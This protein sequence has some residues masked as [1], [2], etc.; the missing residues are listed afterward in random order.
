VSSSSRR[1]FFILIG[2]AEMMM[3]MMIY[4]Y[5]YICTYCESRR[6]NNES[7]EKEAAISE[8]VVKGVLCVCVYKKVVVVS[9]GR[10]C[11]RKHTRH[12]FVECVNSPRWYVW[13][14]LL[15][16]QKGNRSDLFELRKGRRRRTW[17][18]FP[19]YPPLLHLSQIDDHHHS[20]FVN[21][22]FSLQLH[23]IDNSMSDLWHG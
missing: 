4:I 21:L 18:E 23:F 8:V 12:K 20:N 1:L 14:V 19:N 7:W 22:H 17:W 11:I 10:M 9:W 2:K 16:H 15:V 13:T 5:T 6:T 3:T